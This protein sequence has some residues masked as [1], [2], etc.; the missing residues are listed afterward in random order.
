M[1]AARLRASL[2]LFPVMFLLTY[3][4]LPARLGIV[5]RSTGGQL[6]TWPT[7]PAFSS[8]NFVDHFSGSS[9]DSSKWAVLTTGTGSVTVTDSYVDC[10][11]GSNAQSAAYLYYV[12]KLDKTKSQ[13]WTIAVSNMTASGPARSFFVYDSPTAPTLPGT[14]SNWNANVRIT[15]AINSGH[16]LN[17][18]QT[19]YYDLSHTIHTWDGTGN[20]WSTAGVASVQPTRADDYYILGFEIDG[21]RAQWRLLGWCKT[22]TGGYTFEQGLRM[23]ELTDWVPWSNLEAS[24][25][26]WLVL[27]NPYTDNRQRSEFRFEWVRYAENNTPVEGWCNQKQSISVFDPSL[28]HVYSHDGVVFVPQDRTTGAV[29]EDPSHS[30]ENYGVS[31]PCAVYDG[32][33]TDYLF[34][35]G[36]SNSDFAGRICLA[37]APHNG[38]PQNGP[39]R[40]A[41]TTQSFNPKR[42]RL[43]MDSLGY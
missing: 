33:S 2:L 12:N 41:P 7:L 16:S 39:G 42:E 13:L 28:R 17:L 38:F 8:N 10:N 29:S 43:R 4:V 24:T 21:P 22:Y 11:S 27:G 40:R 25:D 36:A 31:E 15:G 1:K 30:W 34:Y 18:L 3:A 14:Y 35:T 20:T 6:T 19:S 5:S 23:F 32:V 26:L 9:L 37:R